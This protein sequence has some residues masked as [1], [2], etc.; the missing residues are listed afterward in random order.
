M[1]RVVGCV[2]AEL[3][4]EHADSRE[5]RKTERRAESA[6]GGG[7]TLP[8]TAPAATFFRRAQAGVRRECRRRHAGRRVIQALTQNAL[9]P[10]APA[11]TF[12][13]VRS[14]AFAAMQASRGRSEL[15]LHFALSAGQRL[16]HAAGRWL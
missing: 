16:T 10:T 11:A 12:S 4:P 6:W 3:P 13:G 9:P 15:S 8:P 14:R 1:P 5:D 2:H 7:P